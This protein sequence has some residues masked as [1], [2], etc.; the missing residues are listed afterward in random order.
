MDAELGVVLGGV[1][2]ELAED[3]LVVVSDQDHFADVGNLGDGL[4]AVTEDG[5]TGD[6]EERLFIC[7]FCQWSDVHICIA[8]TRGNRPWARRETRA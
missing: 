7:I 3:G 5:V 1:F 4:Q 6:F 8:G 2:D